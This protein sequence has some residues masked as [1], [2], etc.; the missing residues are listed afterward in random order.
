MASFAI[1]N[2]GTAQTDPLGI[3]TQVYLSP[4]GTNI[5]NIVYGNGLFA[6]CGNGCRYISNDGQHWQTYINPPILNQASIVYGNGTFVTFGTT[7]T[8][9][10]TTLY[11][12]QNALNYTPIY[13]NA[14]PLLSGVCGNTTWVFIG[15]NQVLVGNQT[16]SGWTWTSFQNDLY[17]DCVSFINGQFIMQLSVG[18]FG[19]YQAGLFFSSTDGVNWQY[20]SSIGNGASSPN[21]RLIYG[22][23]VYF[24]LENGNLLS[25]VDLVNWTNINYNTSISNIVKSYFPSIRTFSGIYVPK[26]YYGGGEFVLSAGYLSCQYINT[27]GILFGGYIY[28]PVLT[29]SDGNNWQLVFTSTNANNTVPVANLAVFG[30]GVFVG[31]GN[32]GNIVESGTLSPINLSNSS[33]LAIATYPGVTING[34]VGQTYQIQYSTS[35]TTNWTGATNIT[36]PYSPYVWVDTSSTV[37]GQRFYRSALVQ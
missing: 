24:S 26:I 1:A 3:W 19:T 12:S 7:G 16:L 18:V 22:N 33:T 20:D 31:I 28:Q 32:P 15:T 2:S 36:L 27:N 37:T 5:A 29:S 11:Q 30:Q 34:T 13:T 17:N 21:D 14:T 23:G 35:L 9:G 4:M 6:G 10:L 8:N 25:S